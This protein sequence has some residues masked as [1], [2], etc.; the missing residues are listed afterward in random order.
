MELRILKDLKSF[1]FV[2]AHSKGVMGMIFR[3][4]AFQRSYGISC[5]ILVQERRETGWPENK[6]REQSSRTPITAKIQDA[7]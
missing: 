5:C 2:T 6:K 7:A 3:I 4:R 1:I